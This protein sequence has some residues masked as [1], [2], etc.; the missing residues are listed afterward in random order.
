MSF[1]DFAE[2]GLNAWNFIGNK[3]VR[4]HRYKACID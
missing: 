2:I 1:D 3:P 4:L